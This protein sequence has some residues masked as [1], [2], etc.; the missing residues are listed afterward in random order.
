MGMKETDKKWK[1]QWSNKKEKESEF[2]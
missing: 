1:S 2:L